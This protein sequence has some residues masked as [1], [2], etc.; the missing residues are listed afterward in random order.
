MT[1]TWRRCVSPQLWLRVASASS[2][3]LEWSNPFF[4]GGGVQAYERRER[5]RG[6]K[7]YELQDNAEEIQNQLSSDLLCE[8]LQ[9]T[10]SAVNPN[11]FRPDHFK[12]LRPDQHRA[13]DFEQKRCATEAQVW[14]PACL[15][16]LFVLLLLARKVDD[17]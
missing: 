8:R 16:A 6:E 17:C 9:T 15:C 14:L 13:I 2:D 12:G 1:T 7:E 5:E 10:I 11:R 4:F 3:W